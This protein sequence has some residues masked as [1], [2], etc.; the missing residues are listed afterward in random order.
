[1]EDKHVLNMN[2]CMAMNTYSEIISAHVYEVLLPIWFSKACFHVYL[3]DIV[4]IY[5]FINLMLRTFCGPRTFKLHQLPKYVSLRYN[6][7]AATNILMR[8]R[9]EIF[10]AIAWTAFTETEM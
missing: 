6:K 3:D 10:D 5:V 1:M 7:C 4:S 9:N 8:H 2:K